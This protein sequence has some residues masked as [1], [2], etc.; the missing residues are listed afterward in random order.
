MFVKT[1][2]YV[3]IGM[4]ALG[5]IIGVVCAIAGYK[6]MGLELLLPLQASFFAQFVM[7]NPPPYVSSLKYLKFSNGFNQIFTYD[8]E[9]FYQGSSKFPKF[10]Y[11]V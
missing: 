7:S 8:Y 6:L 9:Q 1:F 5:I 3:F 4:A 10:D 2:Q 11:E